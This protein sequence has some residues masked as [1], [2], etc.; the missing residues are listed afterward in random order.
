MAYTHKYLQNK[1]D[2]EE[3]IYPQITQ[4]NTDGC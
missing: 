1:L 2:T 3:S 4:I